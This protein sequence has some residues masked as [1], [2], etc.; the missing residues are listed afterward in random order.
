MQQAEEKTATLSPQIVSPTGLEMFSLPNAV[1]GSF[2]DRVDHDGEI[3]ICF[4]AGWGTAKRGVEVNMEVAVLK[5]GRRTLSLP[6][7]AEWELS[8]DADRNS[9]MHVEARGSSHYA[10]FRWDL[11]RSDL[12]AASPGPAQVNYTSV[13]ARFHIDIAHPANGVPCDVTW[14]FSASKTASARPRK[15]MLRKRAYTATSIKTPRKHTNSPSRQRGTGKSDIAT[16]DI[17]SGVVTHEDGSGTSKESRS[18]YVLPWVE[19]D[20]TTVPVKPYYFDSALC[21]QGS[22]VRACVRAWGWGW[23]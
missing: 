8:G 7:A 22:A 17:S 14:L 5:H 1:E 20:W 2:M 19:L 4:T 15:S 12:D 18:F 3:K 10:Y 13:K 23:K 11:S 6:S 16:N 9:A 21:Y